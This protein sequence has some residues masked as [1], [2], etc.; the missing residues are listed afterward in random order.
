MIDLLTK[1]SK[2]FIILSF[3]L[4]YLFFT[5]FLFPKYGNQLHELAGEPVKI[6][7]LYPNYNKEQVMELFTKIKGEGRAIHTFITGRIDMLYPLIYGPL[8]MLLTAF[9]MLKISPTARKGLVAAFTIPL[10]LM[11]TDYC[12]NFTTLQLL[13]TF[14]TLDENVVARGSKLAS[15]KLIMIVL[16]VGMVVFS[17]LFWVLQYV[18]KITFGR[19][20]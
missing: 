15:F 4:A 12:E 3:L 19:N 6:L 11:I 1:W 2:P 9:I 18:L 5:F 13:D 10:L 16:A 20:R 14:P 8:L 7:D 17:A